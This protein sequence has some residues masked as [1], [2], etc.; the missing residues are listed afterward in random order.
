[1][2]IDRSRITLSH[3]LIATAVCGTPATAQQL[4]ATARAY[5]L[6]TLAHPLPANDSAKEVAITL[7]TV[8][9]SGAPRSYQV[10]SIP[11][12]AALSEAADVQVEIIARR[13]VDGGC[14]PARCL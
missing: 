14:D 5:A 12:P 2:T 8:V 13:V 11:V 1:M 9:A 6:V 3:F 4:T 7:P 10:V